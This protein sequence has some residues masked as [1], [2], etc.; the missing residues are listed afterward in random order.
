MDS[1]V[2]IGIGKSTAGVDSIVQQGDF[3][4]LSPGKIMGYKIIYHPWDNPSLQYEDTFYGL[5]FITDECYPK[6]DFSMVL[7]LG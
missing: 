4:P 6:S 3:I 5:Q 1:T 7:S 2:K